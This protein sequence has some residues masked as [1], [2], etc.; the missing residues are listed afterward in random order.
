VQTLEGEL[1]VEIPQV[2]QAAEPFVSKLLPYRAK[3]LRTEP[4]RAMLV[5]AT[6]GGPGARAAVRGGL[7]SLH[8]LPSFLRARPSSLAA[9]CLALVESSHTANS[10]QTPSAIRDPSPHRERRRP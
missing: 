10:V 7:E 5:A 8:Q 1:E 4:P 3:V 2:R 6:T 9:R